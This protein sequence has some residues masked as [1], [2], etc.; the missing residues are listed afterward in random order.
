VLSISKLSIEQSPYY[1]GAAHGRV[2]AVQSLGG[3]DDYYGESG[4]A[5]SAWVGTAAQCLGL[6]GPV[7]D[8]G[9]RRAF[10]GEHPLDGE[11]LRARRGPQR[12]AAIDLTFSAPKSVSL[13]FGVGAP[14]VEA[15]VRGS[16]DEAV[17]A[18][19]GYLERRAVRVRRGRN[20]VRVLPADGFVAATFRHRASRAESDGFAWPQRDGLKW[21]HLALVGV[22]VHLA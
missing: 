3:A 19:L 11:L 9:L 22:V 4:R 7:T 2:D 13:L 21:P 8:Q 10:A 1:V 20:G 6:S 12:N 5:P 15:M 14:D 17:A 16:H 18:A